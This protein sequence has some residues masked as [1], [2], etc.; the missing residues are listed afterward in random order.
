MCIMC[1]CANACMLE[2][3]ATLTRTTCVFK[4]IKGRP[5]LYV[6]RHGGSNIPYTDMSWL[7]IMVLMRCSRLVKN[8]AWHRDHCNENV[9]VR[10]SASGIRSTQAPG[11]GKAMHLGT[12][13]GIATYQLTSDFIETGQAGLQSS[14]TRCKTQ[15]SAFHI[16]AAW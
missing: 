12:T 8:L 11:A 16:C 4:R 9:R 3:H 13:R 10:S 5:C 7:G 14:E 1:M 15:R 6:V 2:P